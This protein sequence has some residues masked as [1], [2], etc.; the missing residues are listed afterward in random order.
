M[1]PVNRATTTTIESV[2]H[3]T[4]TTTS[5]SQ[6]TPSSILG[7]PTS[8]S[9]TPVSFNWEPLC[10]LQAKGDTRIP[11]VAKTTTGFAACPEG[12]DQPWAITNRT[13][14]NGRSRC[15]TDVETVTATTTLALGA[16]TVHAATGE[17]EID[18]ITVGNQVVGLGDEV[19]TP[20]N[21]R[22]LVISTGG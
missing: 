20:L 2:V 13:G 4:L 16:R 15:S 10:L 12:T 3:S 11:T 1:C 17:V 19:V 22:C 7:K 14:S 6:H 5:A 21:D 9:A 8:A 18:G